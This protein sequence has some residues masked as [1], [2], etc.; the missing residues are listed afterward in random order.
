MTRYHTDAVQDGGMHRE[1][2]SVNIFEQVLKIF[3]CLNS[4]KVF[5]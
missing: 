4:K 1:S 5:S 3:Y 2:I